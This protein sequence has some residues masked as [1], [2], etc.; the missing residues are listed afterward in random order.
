MLKIKFLAI[1]RFVVLGIF[2]WLS[3]YLQINLSIP[4]YIDLFVHFYLY[5]SQIQEPFS[6]L[7]K[8]LNQ[9]LDNRRV[10]KFCRNYHVV[11]TFLRVT[12]EGKE[13]RVSFV[14]EKL[15]LSRVLKW[16]NVILLTELKIKQTS[17]LIY[18]ITWSVSSYC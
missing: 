12:S 17:A 3:I 11:W 10:W 9:L 1:T 2:I 5:P 4:I 13:R 18:G 15:E 14:A 7:L 16:T 8:F 6:V